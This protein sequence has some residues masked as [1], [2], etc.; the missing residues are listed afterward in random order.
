MI[1][2]TFYYTIDDVNYIFA[3]KHCIRP[4]QTKVYNN[5]ALIFALSEEI[6]QFKCIISDKVE[7]TRKTYKNYLT[8]KQFIKAATINPMHYLGTQT[9]KC[10]LESYYFYLIGSNKL[11]KLKKH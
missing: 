1:R 9:V 11:T 4:K 10:N 7:T 6:K 2:T 3:V 5:E 8:L